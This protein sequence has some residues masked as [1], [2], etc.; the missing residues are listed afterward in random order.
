MGFRR[1]SA[2]KHPGSWQEE[3]KEGAFSDDDGLELKEPINRS[4]LSRVMLGLGF[5]FRA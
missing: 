5:G 4:Y 2:K 1:V 3:T